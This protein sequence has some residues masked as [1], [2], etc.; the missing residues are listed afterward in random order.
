MVGE[1]E[2]RVHNAQRCS[3]IACGVLR[4]LVFTIVYYH[5]N[6][7][8]VWSVFINEPYRTWTCSTT[9]SSNQ[10]NRMLPK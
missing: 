2:Q 5:N 4:L 6:K 9:H 3:N 1:T 10:K 8:V 7:S